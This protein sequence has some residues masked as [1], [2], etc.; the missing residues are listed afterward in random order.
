VARVERVVQ[1]HVS[2]MAVRDAGVLCG[3]FLLALAGLRDVER[4]DRAGVLC[5]AD[6]RSGERGGSAICPCD[7][8]FPEQMRH[9]ARALPRR[10]DRG[11]QPRHVAR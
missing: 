5:G 4:R 6:L 1:L 7:R 11:R 9:A 2:A 3:R 8:A 10:L